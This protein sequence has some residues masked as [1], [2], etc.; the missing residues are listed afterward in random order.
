MVKTLER[1][2]SSWSSEKAKDDLLTWLLITKSATSVLPRS[3]TIRNRVKFFL[4]VSMLENKI[5]SP[6]NSAA[7]AG[8]TAPIE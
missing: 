4:L 3:D 7:N 5:S 6:Y 1:L 2:P 8:A